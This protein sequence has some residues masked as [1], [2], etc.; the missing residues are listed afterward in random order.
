[1][2]AIPHRPRFHST[3]E[4]NMKRRFTVLAALAALVLGATP[5][6]AWDDFGHRLVARIAW[7]NMTP[8]ARERAIAILRGA[9]VEMGI[10]TGFTGTLS[11]QRQ[12]D[13]FV[14]A[15]SW[16][17]VV[18]DTAQPLR[19]EKYHHPYRHYVDTFWR[20]DTDF[21]PIQAVDRRLEGDLLRDAP[22][23]QGWISSGSAEQKALGLAWILHLVGD[24]HQPL[25]ASGRVT[26]QDPWGDAG[27]NDFRLEVTNPQTNSRRSLHSLWDGIMTSSLQ[28]QSGE[29]DAGFLS[30]AATEVAGRHPR[31]EFSGEIG[32]RQFRDWANA[33]VAIAKQ[34]V[35]AAPLVRNQAAPQAYRQA[36]FR[37][38]EPRVALAGYR[39]ADL[40]NQALGS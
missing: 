17:D 26:P 12:I 18:R 19:M 33:S 39:L 13:L 22:R 15:A 14:S 35:Y 6:Y 23:L 21:G 24:I 20:Q 16:A 25:H 40:L 9:P 32:Q 29:T 2:A 10:R 8:Q 3:W 7:N 1:M 5:A 4:A 11:T 30:R 27:G 31:S 38:A 34:S 28:R 36:A 37:A